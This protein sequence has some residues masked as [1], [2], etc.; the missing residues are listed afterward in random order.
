MKEEM[1]KETEIDK[2][3]KDYF[4]NMINVFGEEYAF[5]TL[6]GKGSIKDKLQYFSSCFDDYSDVDILCA[7]IKSSIIS[8]EIKKSN[9]IVKRFI[10]EG[11]LSELIY[12]ADTNISLR[13]ALIKTF[14]R[15]C[16]STNKETYEKKKIE[17][18]SLGDLLSLF[19][20]EDGLKKNGVKKIAKQM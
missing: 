19:Y 8:N 13:R 18:N 9:L 3:L 7:L 4:K 20:F 11:C 17:G 12:C 5:A 16:Y 6:S 15:Q 10:S 2:K 1:L 14:M